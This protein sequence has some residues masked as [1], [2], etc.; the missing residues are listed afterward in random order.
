MEKKIILHNNCVNHNFIFFYYIE[1][2]GSSLAW[3]AKLKEPLLR[4]YILFYF[5]QLKLCWFFLVSMAKMRIWGRW[6]L[7]LKCIRKNYREQGGDEIDIREL[8]VNYAGFS[9]LVCWSTAAAAAVLCCLSSSFGFNEIR[10]FCW[11]LFCFSRVKRFEFWCMF[12]CEWRWVTSV[13]MLIFFLFLLRLATLDRRRCVRLSNHSPVN[14]A[15][16]WCLKSLNA[17]KVSLYS[18]EKLEF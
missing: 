14:S 5:V 8:E 2:L 13:L 3:S 18:R 10:D 9:R 17:K 11:F 16:S 6:K 1:Q 12:V 4:Q 7:K 15:W